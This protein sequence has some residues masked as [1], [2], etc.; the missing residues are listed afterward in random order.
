MTFVHIRMRTSCECDANSYMHFI[1]TRCECMSLHE[2]AS[3]LSVSFK[4]TM[5]KEVFIR[6]LQRIVGKNLPRGLDTIIYEAGYDAESALATIDSTAIKNIEE[7]INEN[8]SI[9]KD[10]VYED[11]IVNNSVFKLKPGHKAIILNLPKALENYEE[12]KPTNLVQN[13]SKVNTEEEKEGEVLKKNLVD[14]LN[15]FG[16]KYL[17]GF[18]NFSESSIL[19][20]RKEN[21][22]YKCRFECPFCE[23]KYTCTHK[24]FWLVSNF[25]AHLKKDF[26]VV[27][28]EIEPNETVRTLAPDENQIEEKVV[29]YSADHMDEI[30]QILSE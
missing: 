2:C 10:T 15:K 11:I 29:S 17:F 3:E 13:T 22:V 12:K 28:V 4:P 7:Y 14:K 16:K 27:S 21:G 5:A 19:E 24:S 18:N 23:V 26:K 1:W 9:L 6:K 8:K 20:F 30:N 25:E